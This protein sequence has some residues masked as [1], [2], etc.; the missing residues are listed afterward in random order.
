[1]GSKP[2]HRIVIASIAAAVFLTGVSACDQYFTKDITFATK[3]NSGTGSGGSDGTVDAPAD[4]DGDGI[5][6]TIEESFEMDPRAADSDQDGIGD[7]LEFVGQNGDPL[8]RSI[9]PTPFGRSKTGDGNTGESDSDGD[10]LGNTFEEDAGL[11]SDSGDSDGDGFSDALE[12]IADTNPFQDQDFP[13]RNAAPQSDGTPTGAAPTDSDG[14]GIGDATETSNGTDERASDSD[15]DGFSDGVE[16]IMGSA[17]TDAFSVPAFTV[18][19]KPI[20]TPTP[21]A[22]PTG[23]DTGTDTTSEGDF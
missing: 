18:P 2:D 3:K 4:D 1:M 9:S 16:L 23:T 21:T 17:A 12:L 10:G 8:A 15:G 6:N 14:D 22:S 5:A 7:G 13:E 19:A 20:A 11:A